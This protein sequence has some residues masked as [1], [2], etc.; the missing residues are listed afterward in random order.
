MT[1]E[2]FEEQLRQ[3]LVVVVSKRSRDYDRK[4]DRALSW[5]DRESDKITDIVDIYDAARRQY[6][7]LDDQSRINI[8]GQNVG[9]GAY[10]V[11]TLSD[12]DDTPVIRSIAESKAKILADMVDRMVDRG[13]R[14]S[15]VQSLV[16]IFSLGLI[17][18]RAFESHHLTRTLTSVDPQAEN[19]C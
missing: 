6:L 3:M 11:E 4:F 10:L 17:D 12:E 15:L 14:L 9:N 8:A 16:S 2:D 5:V 18:P 7:Q 13:Q 19:G 1:R